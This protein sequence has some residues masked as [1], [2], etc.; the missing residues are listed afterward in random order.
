MTYIVCN[1]EWSFFEGEKKQSHTLK[2]GR[3]LFP[4][5]LHLGGSLPSTLY[6]RMEVLPSHTSFAPPQRAPAL[7]TICKRTK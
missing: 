1:H 2:A 4:F 3:H 5:Q 6:T 7:L